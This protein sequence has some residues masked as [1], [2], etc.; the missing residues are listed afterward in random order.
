MM[1]SEEEIRDLIEYLE[2]SAESSQTNFV[3]V[4]CYSQS[5]ILKWALGGID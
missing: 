3:K 4:R 1:R 2:R 5:Q